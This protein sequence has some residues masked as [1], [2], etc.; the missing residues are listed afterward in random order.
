MAGWFAGEIIKINKQI[1][2]GKRL[3]AGGESDEYHARIW[4]KKSRK[5]KYT[6]LETKNFEEASQEALKHLARYELREEEGLAVFQTTIAK[7]LNDFEPWY[8]KRAVSKDRK[9]LVR[10]QI[11]RFTEYFGTRN[12]TSI[13]VSEFHDYIDW[14]R[15]NNRRGAEKGISNGVLTSEGTLLGMFFGYLANN[16]VIREGLY[17]ALATSDWSKTIGRKEQRGALTVEQFRELRK[18][19]EFWHLEKK[20]DKRARYT[21]QCVHW[22][23]R[24]A[25]RTGLRTIELKNLR[26]EDIKRHGKGCMITAKGKGTIKSER[27]R[28]V[29]SDAGVYDF[30][31]NVKRLVADQGLGVSSTDTVFVKHSGKPAADLWSQNIKIAFRKLSMEVDSKGRKNSL[32]SLRHY[33]ANR[34]ITAGVQIFDLAEYMGTSVS[35]I[36]QYY[37]KPDSEEL[38]MRVMGPSI[39]EKMQHD[40]EV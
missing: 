29:H 39:L 26:W 15:M 38:G 1:A 35:M 18:Y 20:L 6:N 9:T 3:L 31:M 13:T 10:N 17:R 23:V 30:F 25:G 19:V 40:E 14:R 24:I 27:S 12:V 33:F 16:G 5:Y 4:L 22:L 32:Y 34:Q 7:K 2:I 28:N 37:G 11:L 36:Q 21:R 8:L